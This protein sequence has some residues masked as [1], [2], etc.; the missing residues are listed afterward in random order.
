MMIL[1]ACS[2]VTCTNVAIYGQENTVEIPIMNQGEADY[3]T[4]LALTNYKVGVVL[5]S[6]LKS[7]PD[8]DNLRQI[9]DLRGFI[10]NIG[11]HGAVE[12]KNGNFEKADG[13]LKGM[14]SILANLT[15]G[16]SISFSSKEDKQ[17]EALIRTSP[18]RGNEQSVMAFEKSV[19]EL[20][21]SDVKNMN[22]SKAQLATLT[23]NVKTVSDVLHTQDVKVD[24]FT[25]DDVLG[26]SA[27]AF[28]RLPVQSVE[29]NDK[30]SFTSGPDFMTR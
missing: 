7:K 1:G 6:L 19:T 3:I 21:Q 23:G 26:K 17:I 5:D 14:R 4:R 27:E 20:F 9:L 18:K 8:V 11:W 24:L 28:K 16:T 2:F 12:Y 30:S 25:N 15:K 22:L 10:D 29:D 13:A